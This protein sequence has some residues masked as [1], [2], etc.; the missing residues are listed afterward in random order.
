MRYLKLLFVALAALMAAFSFA[1]T[2]ETAVKIS[3]RD[4][5]FRAEIGAELA[6]IEDVAG[7]AILD[8]RLWVGAGTAIGED[9]RVSGSVAALWRVPRAGKGLSVEIGPE[10]R[11]M[12]GKR[13]AFDVV[14]QFALA[15][16]ETA[17]FVFRER[18]GFGLIYSRR[19]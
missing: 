14:A 2:P 19:F 8:F 18:G 16:S 4:P 11:A 12:Q 13:P 5:G 10:Y 15:K 17:A 9:G 6:K 3:V 1:Q 7:I